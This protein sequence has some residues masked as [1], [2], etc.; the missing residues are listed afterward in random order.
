MDA[1]SLTNAEIP[2]T[3]GGKEYRVKKAN[4]QQV[5]EFQRETKKINDEKDAGADLRMVAFAIYLVL[6]SVDKNI[7][8]EQILNDCPGDI[9]VMEILAQL[10]FTSQQKVEMMKRLRD[11]LAE[12][13][14]KK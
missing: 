4:L 8:Q 1:L 7:T 11:A 6:N 5:I 10:G 13:E 2:F 14:K 3:F 12:S 9:D